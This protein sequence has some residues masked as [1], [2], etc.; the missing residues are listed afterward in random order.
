VCILG[1]ECVGLRPA[2][3]KSAERVSDNEVR[4][5]RAHEAF[6]KSLTRGG[7]AVC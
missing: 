1:T 7:E 2:C 6:V 4:V 3:R 5:G